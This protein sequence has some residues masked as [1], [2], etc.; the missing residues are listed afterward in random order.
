[1]RER[2]THKDANENRWK[3]LTV[4]NGDLNSFDPIHVKN[5]VDMLG[6]H[7]KPLALKVSIGFVSS[8]CIETEHLTSCKRTSNLT[9]PYRSFLV[10]THLYWFFIIKSRSWKVTKMN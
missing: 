10:P 8:S 2:E 9:C 3:M 7:N 4:L 6:S 1:M 5:M